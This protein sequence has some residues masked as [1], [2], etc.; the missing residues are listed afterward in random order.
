MAASQRQTHSS[1]GAARAF[2]D[3]FAELLR[4]RRSRFSDV[5]DR[6]ALFRMLE[7]T[8][9]ALIIA[10]WLI[11]RYEQMKARAVSSTSTT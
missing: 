10:D 1:K 4:R 6:V 5:A 3:L 9:A 7:A 2:P 11:A 8:W